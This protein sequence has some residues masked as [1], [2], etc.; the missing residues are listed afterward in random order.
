MGL[1]G[2]Q[3]ALIPCLA[4][5]QKTGNPLA[6]A[7]LG[8]RA[9]HAHVQT[10]CH[11][12]STLRISAITLSH[13]AQAAGTIHTDFERG[14]I[15]AEVMAYDE[16][17]ELG[18]EA[19]VK[20]AGKYRQEVRAHGSTTLTCVVLALGA[21]TR[22]RCGC[23]CEAHS[24]RVA[25]LRCTPLLLQ[26]TPVLGAIRRRLCGSAGCDSGVP[27]CR[28]RITWCW[29]GTSSCS[30]STSPPRARSEG[31]MQ[32]NTAIGCGVCVRSPCWL[33]LQRFCVVL[34]STGCCT[35][36]WHKDSVLPC[37]DGMSTERYLELELAVMIVPAGWG[38]PVGIRTRRAA[39]VR[40]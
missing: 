31:G 34:N 10:V 13:P 35:L 33:R 7:A 6:G 32:P 16:L 12:L 19:A 5:R 38:L 4:F 11:A 29:T 40:E 27:G 17:K 36:L 21:V 24:G 18:S 26:A 30:S 2:H 9:L 15:C 28:G 22:R 23:C 14:F 3:A 25:G 20:A 1:Q 8:G 39:T 37:A